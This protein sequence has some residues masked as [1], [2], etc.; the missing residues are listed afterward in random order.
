MDFNKT[1]LDLVLHPR[2]AALEVSRRERLLEGVLIYLAA[3]AAGAL[4]YSSLPSNLPAGFIDYFPYLAAP[5]PT[6]VFWVGMSA[7]STVF[8][9]LETAATWGL[10]RLFKGRIPFLGL[11]SFLCWIYFL[12]LFM[13]VGMQIGVWARNADAAYFCELAFTFWAFIVAIVGL[14]ATTGRPVLAVF[15]SLLGASL[16]VAGLLIGAHAVG[17]LG[18]E[19]LKVLLLF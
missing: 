7:L 17:V 2:R 10:L 6:G 13:F 1:L 8:F 12:Y 19:Q 5:M 15:V 4:Y 9:L 14:R 3:L 11:L 18:N 16:A